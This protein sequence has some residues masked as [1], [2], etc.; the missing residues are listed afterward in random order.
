MPCSDWGTE[1]AVNLRKR[2]MHVLQQHLELV[3]EDV[4]ARILLATTY[5]SLR[6]ESGAIEHLRIALALRPKDSNIL[7]NAACVYGLFEK[8]SEALAMLKR[9]RDAGYSNWDWISRDPDLACLHGDPEFERL[10]SQA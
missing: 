5:A 10:C 7:Y 9:A 8:K 2:R 3:P 4:R 1:G 6:D